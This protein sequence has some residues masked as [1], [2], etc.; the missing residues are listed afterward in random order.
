MTSSK[1]EIS[2]RTIIFII[3]LLAAIWFVLEIRDILYLLFI[4]YILKSAL[5]PIVESLENR[6]IPKLVSILTIYVA[7][8]GLIMVTIS[9]LVPAL[10]Y[11]TTHFIN[12]FPKY[13]EFIKPYYQIDIASLTQQLTPIG[14]NLISF[15]VNLF[16]NIV[17]MM[18]VLVFT[19]YLLLEHNRI[20][21]GIKRLIPD[22]LAEKVINTI[23]SV[24]SSLGAWLRGEFLLMFMIGLFSFIGLSILKVDYALPLSIIAGFMEIVPIIGPF[25]GGAL[26]VLVALTTSPLLAL[27][28]L[29]L[30][31]IIQQLENNLIVPFVMKR[32][33]NLTPLITIVALMIG[34]KLA[35]ITGAVL[36]IPIVL[37]VRCI[38][39]AVLT[40]D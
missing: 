39:W 14:Q 27:A 33:V 30:Y 9:S 21:N 13:L 32:A 7:L 29:A 24:E 35:G 25:I 11:Q 1:I 34:S 36:A 19:F 20:E 12:N 23:E 10:V 31:F 18:T 15:T 26:A 4:A 5:R 37:M 8:I 16:S 2:H 38:V 3:V 6:R 17:T 40:K 28:V 22:P